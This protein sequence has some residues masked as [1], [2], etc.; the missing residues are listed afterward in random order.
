[1]YFYGLMKAGVRNFDVRKN[2]R[3]FSVGDTITFM[4]YNHETK[5]ITGKEYNVNVT[6]VEGNLTGGVNGDYIV[7]GF[8]PGYNV[9]NPF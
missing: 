2:D 3:R 5:S 1:M 4:E 6:Y 9:S 7:I 8:I